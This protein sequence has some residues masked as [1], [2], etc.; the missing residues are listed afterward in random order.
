MRSSEGISRTLL[1]S[2]SGRWALRLSVWSLSGP[3]AENRAR[4]CRAGIEG[5][6]GLGRR[7]SLSGGAS[8]DALPQTA[9]RTDRSTC[10]SKADRGCGDELAHCES[11][12]DDGFVLLSDSR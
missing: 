11:S 7:G 4:I 1:V 12:S 9:H 10:W 2:P 6:G 5:L 3:A 8:M